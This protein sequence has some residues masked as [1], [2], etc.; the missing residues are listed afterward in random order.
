MNYYLTQLVTLSRAFQ[1]YKLLIYQVLSKID[2]RIWSQYTWVQSWR[3]LILKEKAS[4]VL[5]WLMR[6]CHFLPVQTTK[7]CSQKLKLDELLEKRTLNQDI[8]P[9]VRY[10]CHVSVVLIWENSQLW[11]WHGNIWQSTHQGSC[12]TLQVCIAWSCSWWWLCRRMAT[13]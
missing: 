11:K 9:S 5:H 8:R 3:R 2:Q 12:F 6:E 4:L 13:V 7:H 1:S 10:P